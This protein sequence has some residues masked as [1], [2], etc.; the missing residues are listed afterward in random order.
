M[1]KFTK[2]L[3]VLSLGLATIAVPGTSFAEDANFGILGALF[4]QNGNVTVASAETPAQAVETPVAANAAAK[5]SRHNRPFADLIAK[6]AVEN[7]VP[8]KLAVAIVQIESQFKP[9]VRNGS[10]LGLMQIKTQT[11]RGVGFAGSSAA[12]FNPD[13]NLHF[14]MRYLAQAYRMAGGDTCGTVMRYHSGIGARHMSGADRAYC[15]K[16]KAIMG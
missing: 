8:E 3:A 16:A 15:A 6:H 13:T 12:L 9:H 1:S 10:A 11:A 5:A 14:G 4:S 2:T 7:K